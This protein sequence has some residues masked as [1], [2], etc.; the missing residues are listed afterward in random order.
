MEVITHLFSLIE[1]NDRD[2][3]RIFWSW[4]NGERVIREVDVCA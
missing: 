2:T 1:E 4:I 3:M